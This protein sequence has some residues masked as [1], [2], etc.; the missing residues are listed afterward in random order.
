[1][2]K[3][4][5]IIVARSMTSPTGIFH[6]ILDNRTKTIDEGRRRARRI[7]TVPK[8]RCLCDMTSA[9]LPRVALPREVQMSQ[10]ANMMAVDNSFP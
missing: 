6:R 8:V 10:L 9:I 3:E 2:A 1:M 4:I 7:W 5:A